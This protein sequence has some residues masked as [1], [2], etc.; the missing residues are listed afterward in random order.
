M[1]LMKA[2]RSPPIRARMI[3]VAVAGL[4]SGRMMRQNRWSAVA[5]SAAAASKY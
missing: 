3:R 1:L 5:P 4:D 2:R